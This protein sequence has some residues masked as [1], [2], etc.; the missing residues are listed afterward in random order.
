MR[1]PPGS[2]EVLN[3]CIFISTISYRHL[4]PQPKAFLMA[5]PGSPSLQK[6]RSLDAPLSESQLNDILHGKE[7]RQFV[8]NLQGDDLIWFVDYLDKVRRPVALPTLR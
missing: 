5:S 2:G 8:S 6:L 4:L 1:P 7:Y 3:T